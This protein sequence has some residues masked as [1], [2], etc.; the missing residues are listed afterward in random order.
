MGTLPFYLGQ[1]PE[2]IQVTLSEFMGLSKIK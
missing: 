1:V 2:L